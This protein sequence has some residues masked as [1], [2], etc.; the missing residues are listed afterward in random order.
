MGLKWLNA[1]QTQK[2][3]PFI[4]CEISHGQYVCELVFG[5]DVFILDLWVKIDSIEQPIKS[6][7]MSSGNIFHCGTPSFDNHLSHCFVVLKHIQQRLLNAKIGRLR[8]QGQHYPK[9]LITP[10]DWWRT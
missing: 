1:V 3:I 2:M 10:R 5:V 8:E 4:T 6:N 7:S 9:T